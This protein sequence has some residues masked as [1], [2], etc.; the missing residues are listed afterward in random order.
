M[1]T[2]EQASQ[3]RRERYERALPAA[4][5]Q[6]KEYREANGEAI[7]T[8]QREYWA[9]NRELINARRR[10]RRRAD[11]DRAR[12]T[13]CERRKAPA[14]RRQRSEYNA[15]YRATNR[16]RV[17]EWMREYRKSRASSDPQFKAAVAIRRRFYMAISRHVYEG[18]EVRSGASVR[19]LGCTMAEFVKH[20]ESLWVPGMNWA[21]WSREGWHIDHIRP[22]AAFDLSDHRQL[23][24]VCHYSNM[25]PLWAKDNLS[26]GC[27]G[28]SCVDEKEYR[29][30][31]GPF[32]KQ[33]PRP[34]AGNAG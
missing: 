26:K 29:D 13:E 31:K 30:D 16:S 19:L 17:N 27:R 21:N 7:R 32:R 10:E 1:R 12:A 33:P 20:I 15:R 5:C 24:E 18:C 25:R 3:Q 9:A 34:E 28:V 22:F 11:P 6:Q 23:S 14:V 4:R 8:Q 2:K